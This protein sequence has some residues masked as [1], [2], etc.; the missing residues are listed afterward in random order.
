MERT[1][2][3]DFSVVGTSI[4]EVIRRMYREQESTKASE[5]LPSEAV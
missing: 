1:R 3:S 4:E 5:C 2:I